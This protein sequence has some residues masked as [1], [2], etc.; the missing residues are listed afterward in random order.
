[1]CTS[2][3]F[4]EYPLDNVKIYK[5]LINVREIPVVRRPLKVKKIVIK[6]DTKLKWVDRKFQDLEDELS[7][8]ENDSVYFNF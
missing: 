6:V 1:M 8:K 3:N 7:F 5:V 2:Q 4:N